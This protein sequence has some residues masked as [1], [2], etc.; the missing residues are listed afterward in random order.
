MFDSQIK[1]NR[2]NIIKDTLN[3]VKISGIYKAK[4]GEKFFIIGNFSDSTE[5]YYEDTQVSP[6]VDASYYFIDDVA[7]YNCEGTTLCVDTHTIKEPKSDTF[8]LHIPNIFTPNTDGTNDAWQVQAT[9]VQQL[10][11]AVYN[12]WGTLLWQQ[13]VFADTTQQKTAL[14][15]AW[16]GRSNTGLPVS[17]GTHFYL[18]T[19]TTRQGETKKEKGFVTLMR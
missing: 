8:T 5:V 10:S 2:T 9:G 15:L 17:A 19:Y 4:G 11:A 3:W 1:N 12:R 6:F 18:V 7:V 13:E 14:H 16:D